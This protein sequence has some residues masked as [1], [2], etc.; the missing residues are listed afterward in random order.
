MSGSSHMI[1]FIVCSYRGHDEMYAYSFRLFIRACV[2]M[3]DNI[4]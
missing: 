4:M 2:Y 1:C 3:C